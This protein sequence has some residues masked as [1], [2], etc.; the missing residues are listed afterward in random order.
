MFVALRDLAHARGR[1]A[2][3]AGVVALITVLV[4]FVAGLAGGL[5]AQN[6]TSILEAPGNRIVLAQ[7]SSG[8]SAE[9]ATSELTTAQIDAYRDAP[10]VSDVHPIGISQTW[11]AVGEQRA[12]IALFGVDPDYTAGAPTAPGT[13][14]LPRTAA[15]DLGL[16]TGD[17]LTVSG[18]ELRVA[19]IRDDLWYSHSP[20][21]LV[22]LPQWQEIAAAT[23]RPDAVATALALTS[24]GTDLD[25]VASATGTEASTTL[26][27][28]TALPAFRSE[29]GSLALMIAMLFGI[30]ALVIG[31][32]F[33]VWTL[34]RRGDIAVLKALGASTPSLLR[35]A[36]GQALLV[37]A[38]GIGLGLAIVVG[39]G[40]LARSVMPF[41]LS[42]LTTLLPGAVMILLGLAGAAVALRTVTT[43]DPLTALGSAR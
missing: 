34:Q 26:S 12:S 16:S 17:T 4:G 10:G 11:A 21:A 19:G 25:A 41:L 33:T 43:A 24:D 29:I 22:S 2:L 9:Y 32:F 39:L 6:I 37:L 30:S 27:S 7:A 35:D 5:G 42:P 18:T 3:I 40:L 31:A 38:V 1:F 13:I 14:V 23:G 15:E 8:E 28:L 20:V 36:L